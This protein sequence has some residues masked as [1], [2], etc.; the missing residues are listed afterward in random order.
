MSNHALDRF[1]QEKPVNLTVKE[2]RECEEA[3]RSFIVPVLGDDTKTK[4][5][6]E[7]PYL[8][9]ITVRHANK[10][11]R[12]FP[13][14]TDPALTIRIQPFKALTGITERNG[15]ASITHIEFVIY[16]EKGHFKGTSE[17]G[18]DF[19]CELRLG[20]K[21]REY[22]CRHVCIPHTHNCYQYGLTPADWDFSGAMKYLRHI[23][24]NPCKFLSPSATGRT[25]APENLPQSK[26][27]ATKTKTN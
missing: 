17:K 24:D 20:G 6:D 26:M 3:V 25:P 16:K 12:T 4:A 2:I 10:R 14:Q 7:L 15:K 1:V 22:R 21:E 18:M 9:D 5:H 13:Y 11:E 8:V 27:P 19:S 23:I